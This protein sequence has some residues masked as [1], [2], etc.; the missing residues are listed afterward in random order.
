MGTKIDTT[1]SVGV[2]S[3]MEK[4]FLFLEKLRESGVTN[5]WGAIPY[6]QAEFPEL[7][8]KKAGDILVAWIKHKMEGNQ[9]E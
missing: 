6:L 4:Y 7:S 8:V 9:N 3:C 2:K 1:I 5:M